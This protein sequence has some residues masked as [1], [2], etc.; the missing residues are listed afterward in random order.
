MKMESMPDGNVKV[1]TENAWEAIALSHWMAAFNTY[2]PNE[3]MG[4]AF[5][6]ASE[7]WKKMGLI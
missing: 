4:K 3:V 5:N 2:K 7:W 1:E 6:D